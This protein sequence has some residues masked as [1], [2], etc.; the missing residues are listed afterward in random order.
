MNG[1]ELV[2][3]ALK[4]HEV[5]RVPW[6]PFAGCNAAY[7]IGEKSDNYFRSADLIEKGVT[8]AIKQYE[9]DGIPIMFDLQIEAE[10]LGC[11]LTWAEDNPPSVSS[12]P[13]EQGIAISDLKVPDVTDARYP[14]VAEVT[15]R[16][17][18][19]HGADVA[20]YGLIT[21]PFTLALHLMGPNIFME[22]YDDPEKIYDLMSFCRDVAIMTAKVYIDHGA[23]VV[24]VVDPM[25]SQISPL[26]FEEF[27]TPY[28][29]PV[30]D[31]I[32]EN[33][34]CSS[35]F[36]C[37]DATR[38]IEKMCE[39]GPDNV[40]IDENIPLSY[41]GDVAKKHGV[42]FGGNIPLTTVMLFGTKNDN[43]RAALACVNTGGKTGYILSPGCDMP[44]NTP[45]ENVQAI[46]KVVK[47]E[48]TD[49]SQLPP[50]TEDKSVEVEIPD[51]KNLDKVMVEVF[52]LDAGGC[53]P[54]QYMLD[55]C[56]R[57]APEFG[58]NVEF[59]EHSIKDKKAIA[60]MQALGVKNIPSIVIDGEVTFAS[61]I[62]GNDVLVAEIARH[63][64]KKDLLIKA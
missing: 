53:A 28:A 43:M 2:I 62:P 51:Y 52:T 10:A 31:F 3:S 61:I 27:V 50:E 59:V 54:C 55:A 20:L 6:V 24:A 44:Y 35:F 40:S 14:L 11:E 49:L 30:F 4:G 18:A 8:E 19:R 46:L 25:T 12:H 17:H 57:T 60:L 48:I 47:G 5:E 29:K 33:G 36:V 26:A 23:D 1:K 37:G 63:L 34:K 42:S 56:E 39:C 21:G 41:T 13:L 45:I 16:L 32:R 22:M 9:P 64:A 15:K 38:N 7:L 58:P